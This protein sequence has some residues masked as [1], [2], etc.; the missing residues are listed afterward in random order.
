MIAEPTYKCDQCGACCRHLIVEVYELDITRE[1]KL[2][3]H[4]DRF[5]EGVEGENGEVGLLACGITHPCKL[6]GD[7]NRC[8]IYPT[9]PTG[10][11]LMPA[12]DEQCQM[13]REMAGLPPLEAAKAGEG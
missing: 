13:A 1:P 4:V 2:E 10:C 11:V 5:R 7:D 12:G 8:I 9:R 3:S 6:L